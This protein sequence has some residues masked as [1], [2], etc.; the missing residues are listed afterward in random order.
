MLSRLRRPAHGTSHPT[1]DSAAKPTPNVGPHTDANDNSADTAA[2]SAA[3]PTPNVG[4]HTDANDSSTD[5]AANNAASKSA[6]RVADGAADSKS[7]IADNF[8]RT[9]SPACFRD[10]TNVI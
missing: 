3:K 2:D 10:C 9:D 8:F 5:T 7:H 6:N 1:A 4:P